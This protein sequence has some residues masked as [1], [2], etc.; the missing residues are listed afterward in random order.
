M[1]YML[2]LSVGLFQCSSYI[3]EL[4]VLYLLAQLGFV[5]ENVYLL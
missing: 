3:D 2:I 4:F 1:V 5:I